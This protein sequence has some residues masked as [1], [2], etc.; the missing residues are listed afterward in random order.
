[1]GNKGRCSVRGIFLTLVAGGLGLS[2][3]A[4]PDPK[5][6]NVTLYERPTKTGVPP[7]VSENFPELR[8]DATGYWQVDFRHLASF[9]FGRHKVNYDERPKRF[10][11]TKVAL[12]VPDESDA[13][14][15][16]TEPGTSGPIPD[17]VRALDGKRVCISGYMLPIRMENGLVKDFLLLRNQM[18][19]CYGRQPEPNEWV[20]VKMKDKGV[21][22]KMDTPLNLYGALHVGEMFEGHVFEGLYQLDG[23]KI[24]VN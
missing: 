8:Q 10:G 9:S 16:P 11:R 6:P 7:P 19:C 1:M 18:M 3:Q 20:V 21:P 24:S 4:L 23:E 2:A 14:V 17:N 12:L 13:V 22:S 15:L 5:D